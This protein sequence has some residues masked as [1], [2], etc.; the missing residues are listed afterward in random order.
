MLH[1]ICF[2]FLNFTIVHEHK[3][4]VLQSRALLRMCFV[5][6]RFVL[7]LLPVQT[8]LPSVLVCEEYIYSFFYIYIYTC[9]HGRSNIML[10]V[11]LM[12]SKKEK[13]NLVNVTYDR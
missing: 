3:A 4:A 5:S 1:C 11:A 8:V 2:V 9:Y 12:P 6:L 10:I 7:S 13:K